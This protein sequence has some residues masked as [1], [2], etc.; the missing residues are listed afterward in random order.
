MHPFYKHHRLKTL[1]LCQTGRLLNSAIRKIL[2]YIL[3][4]GA[5]LTIAAIGYGLWILFCSTTSNPHNYKTIGEIPPPFGYHRIDDHDTGYSTYLRSLPLKGRGAD[6]MLYTG[7]KAN[8][9]SLNYAVIDL[10]L[11]SNAEQCA[12]ACMRLRA[13]YLFNTKQYDK[14]HFMDVNHH[15]MRYGGGSSQKSF[16]TYMRQVYATAS[17]YSLT[18]EMQRRELKDMQ[19]G[20]VFV[21]AAC[22]RPGNHKYGHAITVVDVAVNRH[23]KKV[24]LLAEGNTPARNLHV[25]RNFENPIRSPWFTLNENTPVLLLSVFAYKSDELRHF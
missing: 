23:G 16:E 14:I 21:Y 22:N 5:F 19:P 7:G 20:D 17:T 8:Y 12:D 9:Q 24:F 11:L 1:Y 6:V 13:E 15:T 10:P 2:K 4:T 3:L 25:M 18:K